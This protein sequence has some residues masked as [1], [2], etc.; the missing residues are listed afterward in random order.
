M[1]KR[2][3]EPSVNEDGE[4]GFF[5]S[6]TDYEEY[7]KNKQKQQEAY[8]DKVIKE[9]NRKQNKFTNTNMDTID[10]VSLHLTNAQIGYLV[11][12]KDYLDYKGNL[13]H[14][15]KDKTPL[16]T[17][18]F[19]RVLGLV[20][21]ESTFKDFRKKCL[22]AEIM[23]YNGEEKTYS[24]NQNIVFK[25]AFKGMRVVSMVTKGSKEGSKDVKPEELAMIFKL[26]KHVHQKT[27][28]LVKNPEETDLNKLE[29]MK[30][31]ELAEY[32]GVTPSYLSQKLYK[33]VINNEYIVARIK[34]GKEPT[35]FMLNPNIFFRGDY[36]KVQEDIAI[37]VAPFFR[38]N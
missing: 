10:Y 7:L 22:E 12:L 6:Q 2:Y 19:L 23:F 33:I 30:A 14:S 37:N 1:K 20:G 9:N 4:I 16:K 29:F 24:I 27:M 38:K 8:K 36:S 17:A 3:L 15:Q 13:V 31:K 26:Q 34:A 32:L 35:K 21:K 28:A 5:M 11:I 18:D 25:G